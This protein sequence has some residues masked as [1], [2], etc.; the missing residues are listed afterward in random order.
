MRIAVIPARGGSKRIPRKNIK[1]FYGKP[2]IAWSILAAQET[3]LFE[4]IIVS[5]EDAEIAEIARYWGAE[6]PFARPVELADDLTPTAPVIVHAVNYYER[7]GYPVEWA[8]C[9]YSCAPLVQAADMKEAMRLALYRD[10]D[11]VYPVVR[12]AHPIQ[13]A[14]VM[15]SGEK[16]RFLQPQYELTRTQDLSPSYYDAGQFYLGKG[17]AWREGKRMHSGGIGLPIPHWR[18]ADIDTPEDWRRAEML[19]AQT[20]QG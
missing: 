3:G 14:M 18:A 20:R 9:I 17:R 2:V 5:T 8:C 7:L 19:F 11:F 6:T 1:D 12:Y 13:R 10:A 4:A 16:M 15:D